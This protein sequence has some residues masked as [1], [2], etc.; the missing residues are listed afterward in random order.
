M[1]KFTKADEDKLRYDLIPPTLLEDVAR[2]LTFGAKKYEPNNWKKVD[3][4]SRY[5]AALYRHLEAWRA[6]EIT[7]QESGLS[8]L[9]HAAT[10]IAF[11]IELNHQP[12]EWIPNYW[13]TE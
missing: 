5:T 6:G 7:D 4:P 13:D 8:H 12:E 3:D 10:N 9:S 2:V 1:E 11:L